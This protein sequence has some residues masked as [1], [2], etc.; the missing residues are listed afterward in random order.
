MPRHASLGP[1]RDRCVLL[2][3]ADDAYEPDYGSKDHHTAKAGVR[4][5]SPLSASGKCQSP[6]V[7]NL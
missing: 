3:A 5:A 2:R 7:L 4:S 1:V 6:E